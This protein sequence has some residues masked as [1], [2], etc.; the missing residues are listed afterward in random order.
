MDTPAS[1]KALMNPLGSSSKIWSSKEPLVEDESSEGIRQ[2]TRIPFSTQLL[3]LIFPYLDAPSLKS[4]RSV[5][6]LWAELSTSFLGKW[7]SVTF[8]TENCCREE[9]SKSSKELGSLH[10]KLAKSVVLVLAQPPCGWISL[11]KNLTTNLPHIS[12]HIVEFDVTLSS[13]FEPTLERMWMMHHFPNLGLLT[14]TF[15]MINIDTSDNSENED[16]NYNENHPPHKIP[17]FL[18]LP[19]LKSLKIVVKDKSE[20]DQDDGISSICQGLLNS[21]ACV[22]NVTIDASFYPD[23]TPCTKL[24]MLAYTFIHFEDFGQVYVDIP[25]LTWMLGTCRNYLT[26]LTLSGQHD[27]EAFD[28]GTLMLPSMPNL[29]VLH[30]EE[31]FPL[32]NFLHSVHLPS[33]PHFDLPHKQITSLDVEAVYRYFDQDVE[34]AAR[35]VRLFPS[36]KKFRFKMTILDEGEDD[37]HVMELLQSFATWDLTSGLVEIESDQE[38]TDVLAVLRG[39]AMWKGLSRTSVNFEVKGSPKFVLDDEMEEILLYCRSLRW[40]KMSGFQMEEEER[41]KF[42]EF[43]EEHALQI[44]LLNWVN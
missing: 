27:W 39:V 4:A 28:P 25:I 11:P 34:T 15:V 9:I 8:T 1:T 32:G 18:N 12:D 2:V 26:R 29:V 7:T 38:T 21:A 10:P 31:I 36:V 42:E 22:E 37:P 24:D 14:L 17:Q 6:T 40:I 43:I 41:E 3:N 13:R 35:I 23:F 30:I 33:D 5:C 20:I 19:N 16:D 44:S